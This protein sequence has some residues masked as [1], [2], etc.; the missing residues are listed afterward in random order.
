MMLAWVSSLP[1]QYALCRIHRQDR[2][3]RPRISD[4]LCQYHEGLPKSQRPDRG[5]RQKLESRRDAV[6][7]AVERKGRVVGQHRVRRQSRSHHV[8]IHRRVLRGATGRDDGV[9]A[10]ADT[11]NPLP[12][13]V[14]REQRLARR[15]VTGATP[16]LEVPELLAGE[17]RVLSQKVT[18]LRTEP[19]LTI[20]AIRT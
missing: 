4:A 11:H 16:V 7:P 5:G 17:H 10:A 13:F 6:S 18:A 1:G 15:C 19:C 20:S 12:A 3:R 8:W 9:N 2:P 14:V